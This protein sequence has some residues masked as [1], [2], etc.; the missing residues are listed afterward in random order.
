MQLNHLSHRLRHTGKYATCENIYSFSMFYHEQ[1][2]QY[3]TKTI[4]C[5]NI[6]KNNLIWC[7]LLQSYQYLPFVTFYNSTPPPPPHSPHPQTPTPMCIL[8]AMT[9]HLL[10]GWEGFGLRRL[11]S[12]PLAG[13]KPQ[14]TVSNMRSFWLVHYKTM[15]TEIG[16]NKDLRNVFWV[17]SD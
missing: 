17:I 14:S 12:L 10:L 4:F 13:L 11:L 5:H 3:P 7:R 2:N 1:K 6:L 9:T 15:L 8:V 16:P